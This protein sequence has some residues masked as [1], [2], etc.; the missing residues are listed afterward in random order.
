MYTRTLLVFLLIG[1]LVSANAQNKTAFVSGPMLGAVELRTAKVWC[2]V[3]S[4]TDKVTL[5]LR[6]EGSSGSPRLV[7]YKGKLGEDFNPVLFEIGGLDFNTTYTYEIEA[8]AANALYKKSGS[9]TTTDL[10]QYRRNFPDFTFL[11]GSCS[12]F[13]EP[14]FDRQFTEMINPKTVARPYGGDS[15]IFETMAREKSAF[16]LWLGDNWY[17]RDV[18]YGSTWG[19]KYRAS[20]DRS[21]PVMQNFWKAMPHYAVWDDHD[22]GPNDA[23]KSYVLKE[24]AR[25]IFMRYW[26]NPSYGQHGQGIYTKFTYSD[27]DFFLLDDRWFRSNDYMATTVDGKPNPDKRMWG[28]QQMEW[29]KNALK[30]SLATFKI[31]ITG[32]QVLNPASPYDC[33]Q[34]YPIE[35]NELMEYLG[36]ERINGLVFFTGDRHHSEV[37]RYERPGAYTLYDVTSSPLTSGVG[38]VRDQEA[39]NPARVPG[40]LVEVQNYSRVSVT[41]GP[42]ERVLKVEYLGIK[43]EKLAEWSVKASDLRNREQQQ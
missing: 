14:K 35:F 20:R 6:K 15:S 3:T 41:G 1:T 11:T 21:L 37:I 8:R 23:D 42:R 40:T 18:D 39:D 28:P 22:Y 32:S 4:Q 34:K 12:Y 16:M 17:Y 36:R 27:V 19:L 33:L 9:F 7:Q 25:D 31:V 10:W 2:E 30:S 26:G 38:K 29:L 5:S 13:N 43:G 24:T